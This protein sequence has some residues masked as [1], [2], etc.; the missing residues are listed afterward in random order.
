[1]KKYNLFIL[2][3]VLG[4]L[5]SLPIFAQQG[6]MDWTQVTDSAQW[7]G[8][9]QHT[10]V[11]FNNML[12]VMGGNAT[13]TNRKN[14]VWYSSNETSWTCATDS[15]NWAPRYNH[16]SVVFNNKI[17]VLG[18]YNRTNDVW[19]SSDG[20]NWTRATNAASW[21]R[22]DGHAVVVFDN[23]LWVLGGYAVS[24][25][26]MNDV[27]YS[28][29]GISWTLAT[30]SAGW[31]RRDNHATVVY[32]NKMWVI[33]GYAASGG[34]TND[35]WYSSDGVNWTEATDSAGWSR[36]E[37]HT[38][39][40][41]DNKMW[42]LGGY[43]GRKND[44]WFSSDGANWIQA[45]NAAGWT[46][47]YEHTAVVFDNKMWVIGGNASDGNRKKDVWFSKGYNAVLI[48]PN[49]ND[50]LCGGETQTIKWRTNLTESTQI[51]LL[52]SIDGGLTYLDTIAS[53][54]L[55][56]ETT[57]QWTIPFIN[58]KQCRVMVQVVDNDSVRVQDASDYNFM[59][60]TLY[61]TYP[62]GNETLVGGNNQIIRWQTTYSGSVLYR[63][64]FTSDTGLTY[65]TIANNLTVADTIY[66]W[67]IPLINSES[68]QILIQMID[69]TGLAIL[70]DANDNYFTVRTI[71]MII[72]NGNEIWQGGSN[73]I[74]KWQTYTGITF[75][76][77]RLLLSQDDGATFTDTIAHN[78]A[79]FEST[80]IWILP[81]I[82][83][84]QCRVKVQIIN[85]SDSVISSDV[86]D[87]KFTID[88][89]SPSNFSL[90]A[91]VNNGWVGRNANFSWQSAIDNFG[92]SYYELSVA[93]PND[94]LHT[95]SN[96][97]SYSYTAGEGDSWICATQAAS[98]SGRN[99]HSSVVFN[100]KM[101]VLGGEDLSAV[102][103][104][105][106][107]STDGANWLQACSLSG[108]TSRLDYSAVVFDNKIWVMG[109]TDYDN[110]FNDV[111]YSTDGINWIQAI[112]SA[113]WSKRVGHTSVVFDNK[114]WVIGGYN[115]NE[116]VLNDVWYSSDGVNWVQ[117][118]AS[119]EWE[120]RVGH[121]SVV[122]DNKIWV[123]GGGFN[124][125]WYSS[126][127]IN[128]IQAT[129]SAGWSARSGHTSV[130]FDGKMWVIGAYDDVWFSSDGVSWIQAASSV[131]WSERSGHT[132]VVYDNKIWVIGGFDGATYRNDVWYSNLA[133]HMPEG[134]HNWWV[135]AF[136]RAGNFHQ[137]NEVFSV[138]VDTGLPVIPTLILPADSAVLGDS[139]V[140]FIWYH[141]A[142]SLS[143]LMKY[144]FHIADNSNFTEPRVI[145]T[146]DTLIN[147]AL[148]DSI[149]WWRV[150]A[151]DSANNKSD[152]TEIRFFRVLTS[153]IEE[154][155]VSPN[156][157][158]L[159]LN[160]FPN[161]I[162]S[163]ATIR[164]TM[165]SKGKISL[166]LYDA[167][168]RLV[169][170]FENSE[171]NRGVYRV[172]FNTAELSA[173]VYFISMRF[174]SQKA[175]IK[176]LV[177]VK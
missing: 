157:L 45:T 7:T 107:Y 23:K 70:Q 46:K 174:A 83:S 19:Y 66:N 134:N 123:I 105:V 27:W 176:R 149:Y 117:A 8:R 17:W 158:F 50:T 98:W 71:K 161:P 133:L 164:Y 146:P 40:V 163:S 101:W 78:I 60:Q 169:K 69:S 25:G 67:I 114:I 49:G 165:P 88:S 122:F 102:R 139:F 37:G 113:P 97:N 159:S 82:N 24:T 3:F 138:R 120:P 167:V 148:N 35:V 144:R 96:I 75:L 39:M 36:R 112:E 18:G 86:S 59:V 140:T 136:D 121:T 58:S 153:G 127:G 31:S 145:D 26:R 34:R 177:I 73:K 62:N 151:I 175:I 61:I 76:H 124:D 52:L 126:D 38:A 48:F 84:N 154:N 64:L 108:W 20:V 118:T 91:P 143:G 116:E 10:S 14:D 47:R 125:V 9:N 22:R 2:L 129:A 99:E 170:S 92:M 79:S 89:D 160:I 42:L 109:G 155:Q 30:D 110:L 132:S 5:F 16:A 77:Y 6:S 141:S 156:A 90:L 106:W 53:N 171:R 115:S 103:N 68:C 94:T 4:S 162:K 131:S 80:Y 72:P 172:N 119:A 65:D 74:I 104:D 130:V 85:T 1:M 57:Y 55:P 11:V 56:S 43:N 173:G 15:A 135:T 147:L 12:W 44:V 93:L 87:E 63:L 33:G 54:I 81:N 95:T 51:R 28:T 32:D 128:W 142:D 150:C 41:F 13:D 100:G 152:W 21:S 168:G 166:V 29:D 137:S 111:W